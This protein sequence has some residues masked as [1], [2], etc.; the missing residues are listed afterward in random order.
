[1]F[2]QGCLVLGPVRP[3]VGFESSRLG[4]L[5]KTHLLNCPF[6]QNLLAADWVIR[7]PGGNSPVAAVGHQLMG[8]HIIG[9]AGLEG[10]N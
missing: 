8:F 5:C 10:M 1:M 4:L 9:E 2:H 7:V 3:P 6:V